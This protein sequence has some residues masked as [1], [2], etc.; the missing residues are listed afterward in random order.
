MVLNSSCYD[1]ALCIKNM[2]KA[3]CSLINIEKTCFQGRG[4]TENIIKEVH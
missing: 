3:K 4:K 1:T 2:Q